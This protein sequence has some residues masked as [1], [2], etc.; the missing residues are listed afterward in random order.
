MKKLV[1]IAIPLSNREGFNGGEKMSLKHLNH[2]LG[3]Y[4]RYFIAPPHLSVTLQ[5][6]IK[7]KVFEPH[8]FGSVDAHRRLLFSKQ[9]YKAFAEYEFLLIYH[10]DALVFSNELEYWC[11]QGFDYIA[12][13]WI[14]HKDAPYAGMPEFENKV[15]NGGFSLRRIDSFLKVL[16]SRRLWQSPNARLLNIFQS[17]IKTPYKLKAAIK[18]LHLFIPQLNGINNELDAYK[19]PEDHFWANRATYY[20]PD[21]KIASVSEA[22]P[23]AFE[24]VP[25]YCYDIT[26]N[27]LPFGCHAWERYDKAFWLPFLLTS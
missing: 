16:K 4:D 24:C 7:L 9:F 27:T 15:G 17:N 2:F 14:T 3:E 11:N 12:P 22:L 21:F 6:G 13:P 19:A 18:A 5:E 8:F 20:S 23:F 10:L 25:R 26:H 1:A